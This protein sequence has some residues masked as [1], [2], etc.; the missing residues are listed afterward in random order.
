MLKHADKATKRAAPVAKPRADPM[1]I[2]AVYRDTME[3]FPNTMAL[4][5]E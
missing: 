4:L 2:R 1:D 5:A 3:R